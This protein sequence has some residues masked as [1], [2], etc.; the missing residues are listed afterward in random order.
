MNRI[1]QWPLSAPAPTVNTSS[2]LSL[3]ERYIL[4]LRNEKLRQA[5]IEHRDKELKAICENVIAGKDVEQQARVLLGRI[6][7]RN[8]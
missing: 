8:A 7:L 3:R 2:E 4:S 5:Q 6:A 1:I